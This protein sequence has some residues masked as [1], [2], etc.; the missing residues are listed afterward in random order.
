[1]KVWNPQSL[2]ILWKKKYP[3]SKFK[4]ETVR[5]WKFKQEK[6]CKENMALTDTLWPMLFSMPQVKAASLSEI[7][8]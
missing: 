1:M 5:D 6:F 7:Y 3:K 4:R 2:Q 8:Q